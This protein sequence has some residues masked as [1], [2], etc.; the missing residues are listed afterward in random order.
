MRQRGEQPRFHAPLESGTTVFDG[1]G[2][3]RIEHISHVT[4]ARRDLDDLASFAGSRKYTYG[5]A[6]QA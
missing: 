1:I 4:I 6:G 5:T 3:Q 2:E